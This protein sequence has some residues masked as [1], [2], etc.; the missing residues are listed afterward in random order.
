MSHDILRLGVKWL[1][2]LSDRLFDRHFSTYT[3]KFSIIH[4]AET[5]HFCMTGLVVLC[6]ELTRLK[7]SIL[8]RLNYTRERDVKSAH[9]V[10]CPEYTNYCRQM[11]RRKV[12]DSELCMKLDLFSVNREFHELKALCTVAK[13]PIS[14]TEIPTHQR[15]IIIVSAFGVK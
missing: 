3:G 2:N 12:L 7:T 10:T 8:A 9:V 1:K 4:I 15:P 11:V 13:S 14:L 5:C 6:I